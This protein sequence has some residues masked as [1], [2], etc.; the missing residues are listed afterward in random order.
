[1][2]LDPHEL[3]LD[4]L[5]E[6]NPQLQV[7]D[8]RDDGLAETMKYA[9]SK[10][11]EVV[12]TNFQLP[13]PPEL[14]DLF[15]RRMRERIHAFVGLLGMPVMRKDMRVTVGGAEV[16]C[17]SKFFLH[18]HCSGGDEIESDLGRGVK[19]YNVARFEFDPGA[20]RKRMAALVM[21]CA[22]FEDAERY[23][24]LHAGIDALERSVSERKEVVL[25]ILLE[26]GE[27]MLDDQSLISGLK[28]AKA[29][30]FEALTDLDAERKELDSLRTLCPP[31]EEAAA[32]LSALSDAC[33]VL[34]TR[35]GSF[36]FLPRYVFS[37]LEASSH[38]Q[39]E[40]C[41][42]VATS[43]VRRLVPSLHKDFRPHLVV[44]S[45]ALI[46]VDVA[47]L[48][49]LVAAFEE[50]LDEALDTDDDEIAGLFSARFPTLRGGKGEF[51]RD[52]AEAIVDLLAEEEKVVDA[53]LEA[54]ARRPTYVLNDPADVES[55]I[56]SIDLL[57]WLARRERTT[58]PKLV[59]LRDW[60]KATGSR[61]LGEEAIA[62]L[63]GLVYNCARER[64]WIILD[65]A[66]ALSGRIG[67]L[68]A[69]QQAGV[70]NR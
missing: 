49:D 57:F 5:R 21:R 35:D 46:H 29:K 3:G 36:E 42:R 41:R 27:A 51:D 12:V 14:R 62:E 56:P 11:S 31:Y 64:R 34:R 2:L 65:G 53:L 9:V 37:E 20:L 39:E 59:S 52:A 25:R 54:S 68:K 13:A 43:C 40:V 26:A 4:Y 18:L 58:R 33:E 6:Q 45:A 63:N 16:V 8:F 50:N 70:A 30:V 7:V 24:D 44:F 55:H 47:E 60:T 22:G 69:A 48:D 1:M 66:A 38:P 10:G 15:E 19:M 28:D 61:R 32:R 23:D 17:H 67:E